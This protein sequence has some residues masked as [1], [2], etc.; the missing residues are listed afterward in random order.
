MK[1]KKLDLKD[2][3]HFKVIGV[4]IAIAL[5]ISLTCS[6]TVAWICSIVLLVWDILYCGPREFLSACKKAPFALPLLLFIVCSLLSGLFAGGFKEFIDT[7]STARGFITYFI[8][9]IACRDPQLRRFFLLSFLSSASLSGLFGCVQQIFNFHPFSKQYLQGTGF[10]TAPMPFAGIMQ[11]ASFLSLA[12]LLGKESQVGK[13]ARPLVLFF[14]LGTFLGLIFAAERS[15]WLGMAFGLMAI[16]LKIS[17]KAFL[18]GLV[19][20][21]LGAGLGYLFVP[22]VKQRC[23][24]LLNGEKD[25]SITARQVIWQKAIDTF[26]EHPLLGV[27]PRKFPVVVMPEATQMM[28]SKDL[29][30]GHSNYMHILATCGLL[31]ILAFLYLLFVSLRQLFLSAADDSINLGLFAA[32]ISLSVAGIF[33]YNFGTGIV[34]LAQW[35]CLGLYRP[36]SNS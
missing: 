8:A 17:R 12:L 22:V 27:G 29:N 10:L 30:H 34:R 31:G 35:F 4:L 18:A 24:S 16:C 32:L 11:L 9:F 20:L 23:Q 28:E 19:V 3:R 1:T 25:A 2:N 26:K 36:K 14:V 7:L 33:E 6:L 15:A 21:V 13:I 5:G